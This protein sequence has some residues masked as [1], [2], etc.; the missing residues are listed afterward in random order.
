[1]GKDKQ[2][3]RPFLARIIPGLSS[4]SKRG[5]A[6]WM[7]IIGAVI[8]SFIVLMTLFAPWI[9]PH[10]PIQLNVG[11]ILAPPS[12]QFPLGTTNLGQ[13]MLSRIIYGGSI[14]LQVALLAVTV[15]LLIGVPLGLFSS[16]TGGKIDRTISLF[17]D[18]MYAFP[19]LVLAIA[20][21]SVLGRGVVNMAVAISVVYIPSYFRVIRSQVLT[22][23]EIPY[24][25]A[26]RSIG[27]KSRTILFSYIA[28]NVLPSIITVATVNFADAIL[29]AA[30]LTFIGLGVEVNIPDWGRDLTN[31]AAVLPAGAWW[32]IV[33]P[34]IMIILLAMGFT[35]MGEGL[36]EL[37][38]P[39]L[40][41]RGA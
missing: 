32:V 34:G 15:C 38:N 12:A 10:N 39:K 29:T 36:G 14:S 25:E 2:E 9:A 24:T 17:M 35:L 40:Q 20:I 28:P 26:A 3:R 31:G 41:E 4:L 21:A 1:M 19:G 33:F 30:G 18:S 16:F 23:K 37:F 27:A 22:I 8:V 13:D 11:P 6:G 7:V 5:M